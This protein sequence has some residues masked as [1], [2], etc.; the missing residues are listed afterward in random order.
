[1]QRSEPA[2][3]LS[4]SCL[5]PFLRIRVESRALGLPV[6][7]IYRSLRR[8]RGLLATFYVRMFLREAL[9]SQPPMR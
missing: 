3:L 4:S 5:R 1:M 8:A 7:C 2:R 6:R 9:P